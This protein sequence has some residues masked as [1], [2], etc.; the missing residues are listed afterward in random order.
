MS[1]LCEH[2]RKGGSAGVTL[3]EFSSDSRTESWHGNHGGVQEPLLDHDAM[4]CSI[5]A[6]RSGNDARRSLFSRDGAFAD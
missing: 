2:C 3:H 5:E 1:N 6:D 4:R